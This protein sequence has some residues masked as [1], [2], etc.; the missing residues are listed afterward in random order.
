M[1]STW[2]R[3]DT[4]TDRLRVYGGWI[5]RSFAGYV[6]NKTVHQV[7]VQDEG[8]RWTLTEEVEDGVR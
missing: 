8:H 1:N 3:I 6:E 5:V 2:E 4:T 7:F